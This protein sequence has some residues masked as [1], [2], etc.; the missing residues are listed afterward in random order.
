MEKCGQGNWIQH[1]RIWRT[2]RA[3]P[4]ERYRCTT[5]TT[6]TNASGKI[7]TP[8][9]LSDTMTLLPCES[10]ASGLAKVFPHCLCFELQAHLSPAK[11]YKTWKVK[12]RLCV[13]AA[14]V[15][16]P[17]ELAAWPV[18]SDLA[19]TLRSSRSALPNVLI[20]EKWL[21]MRRGDCEAFTHF[22]G[23]KYP[24]LMLRPACCSWRQREIWKGKTQTSNTCLSQKSERCRCQTPWIDFVAFVFPK[25]GRIEF[26]SAS[27][28]HVPNAKQ[29]WHK[30]PLEY[31]RKFGREA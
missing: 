30:P 20:C 8:V 10:M 9:P 22:Q 25:E 21:R 6:N 17:S 19:A 31:F 13:A 18:H 12:G 14:A 28:H 4:R 26:I 15:C 16:L 23:V 27:R 5:S 11:I 24:A 3:H 7:L 1:S 29:Y 2:D